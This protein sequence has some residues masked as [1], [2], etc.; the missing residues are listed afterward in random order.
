MSTA[1]IADTIVEPSPRSSVLPKQ[2]ELPKGIKDKPTIPS[3]IPPSA[4][5]TLVCIHDLRNY[6]EPY[7]ILP[8]LGTLFRWHW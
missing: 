3:V 5:R 6:F 7:L 2:P 4:P 8:I 1:S